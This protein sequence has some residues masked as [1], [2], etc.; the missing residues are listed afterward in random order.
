MSSFLFKWKGKQLQG[1]TVNKRKKDS[2]ILKLYPKPYT[3]HIPKHLRDVNLQPG[4]IVAVGKTLA[5][6]LVT[7]VFRKEFEETEKQ[8]ERV[9]RLLEKAPMR[10]IE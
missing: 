5:S 6:F 1:S 3:W 4:D 10:A 9:I 2:D 8:Y 7:R